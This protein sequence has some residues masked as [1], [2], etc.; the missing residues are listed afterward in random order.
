MEL[1]TTHY[2]QIPLTSGLHSQT[3]TDEGDY[4]LQE[5]LSLRDLRRLEGYSPALNDTMSKA[6]WNATKAKLIQLF[7]LGIKFCLRN[8]ALSTEDIALYLPS[9]ISV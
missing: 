1:L 8:S 9:G 4:V 7:R 2:Q 3:T 6:D 5:P